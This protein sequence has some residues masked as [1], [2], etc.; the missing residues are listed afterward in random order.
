L[1]FANQ[2]HY[3]MRDAEQRSAVVQLFAHSDA[4]FL[5]HADS[6]SHSGIHFT[7]GK[8]TGVFHARSQKQKM[9]TL[10]STEADVYA[11]IK[12]AKNAIFFRD[13]LP[14][15]TYQQLEPTTLF[16]DNK[17]A[18]ALSKPLTG[19][20]R[21]V[22]HFKARLKFLI[23]Q[24]ELQVLKLEHLVG[25][26]HSSDILSKPKS[27][28]G[29]EKNTFELMGPQRPSAEVSLQT[30]QQKQMDYHHSAV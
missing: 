24:V 15:L 26:I 18:I 2:T 29:H 25:T 28:P 12:H 27:R 13:V 30:V 3:N 8:E 5:T 14:E 6:K 17:K 20:H 9:A 4:A 11:A 16:I 22:R 19:D 10:S 1:Q 21:K 7:L 23:E